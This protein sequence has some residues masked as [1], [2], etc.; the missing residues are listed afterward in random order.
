MRIS[1][2]NANELNRR[3][4]SIYQ[5]VGKLYENEKKNHKTKPQ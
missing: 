3:M 4:N 1:R 2:K 5:M